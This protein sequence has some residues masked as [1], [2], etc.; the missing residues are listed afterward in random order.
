M[1]SVYVCDLRVACYMEIQRMVLNTIG[2]YLDK[3][4]RLFHGTDVQVL[5]V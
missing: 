5:D 2:V 4:K 1:E 3:G